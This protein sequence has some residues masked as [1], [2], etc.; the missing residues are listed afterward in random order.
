VAESRN[1]NHVHKRFT[2]FIWEPWRSYRPSGSS[3]QVIATSP[4]G[5]V[6]WSNS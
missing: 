1:R 6:A 4:S 5:C 2:Q 3:A